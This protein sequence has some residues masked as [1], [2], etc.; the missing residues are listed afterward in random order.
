MKK[1]ISIAVVAGSFV[2]MAPLAQASNLVFTSSC[3]TPSATSMIVSVDNRE[4]SDAS[5]SWSRTDGNKG[6]VE[7]GT[8]VARAIAVT[9]FNVGRSTTGSGQIYV[10]IQ[11]KANSNSYDEAY[12]SEG[13][14]CFPAAV[15]QAPATFPVPVVAPATPSARIL[16]VNG[17]TAV[18]SD[19]PKT[20]DE[21][22]VWLI[23][24]LS[25]LLN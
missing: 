10:R 14:T 8:G 3:Q 15:V 23:D 11:S 24:R 21:I 9:T 19:N 16:V 5:F 2:L 18:I 17:K 25:A 12:L 4:A 7:N 13:P 6:I 20:A 22:L 1:L